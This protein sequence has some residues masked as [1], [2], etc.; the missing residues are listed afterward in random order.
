MR[1]IDLKQPA[2]EGRPLAKRKHEPVAKEQPRARNAIIK[3]RAT[4]TYEAVTDPELADAI[5]S[6]N[7]RLNAVELNLG[8]LMRDG[9]VTQTPGPAIVAPKSNVVP[10]SEARKERGEAVQVSQPGNEA[11][12][13]V[14]P[15]SNEPV[16]VEE[17]PPLKTGNT[18]PKVVG[19]VVTIS[20]GDAA[21][22][23][24]IPDGPTVALE[25]VAPPVVVR[26]AEALA[27]AY[28]MDIYEASEILC[29][30]YMEREAHCIKRH[31]M[32]R[33]EVKVDRYLAQKG[34]V[35]TNPALQV[36]IKAENSGFKAWSRGLYQREC[37]LK[38][39]R[40]KPQPRS[41]SKLAPGEMAYR[42][43]Q[44]MKRAAAR[45][46]GPIPGLVKVDTIAAKL[47]TNGPGVTTS[48]QAAVFSTL[49][50]D[51]YQRGR[52]L[53]GMEP[54]VRG[55][56]KRTAAEVA[57]ALSEGGGSINAR[58]Q[59][60]APVDLIKEGEP[61]TQAELVRRYQRTGIGY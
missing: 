15:R 57:Y 49:A 14:L 38:A 56:T 50:W 47:R 34:I 30:V 11:E 32:P 13:L 59:A 61:V 8:K 53:F 45:Q 55:M 3:D 60:T 16:V 52:K 22:D 28:D 27:D 17:A 5:N 4:G 54:T 21:N 10:M 31:G 12:V 1:V 18:E 51:L 46:K 44:L 36:Y 37:E 23:E 20:S 48:S 26:H 40:S 43:K 9:V 2:N 39:N 33:K 41:G 42:K 35:E 25:A 7:L 58:R 24:T 19:K 29:K 6:I